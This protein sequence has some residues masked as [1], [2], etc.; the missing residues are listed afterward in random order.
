MQGSYDFH[1]DLI[2]V[3][4]H[5]LPLQDLLLVLG[6]QEHWKDSCVCVQIKFN[7]LK[8][9]PWDGIS[10]QFYDIKKKCPTFLRTQRSTNHVLQQ[11][12]GRELYETIE[13]RV[14]KKPFEQLRKRQLFRRLLKLP[15][16]DLALNL[17]L[18]VGCLPLQPP[19]IAFHDIGELCFVE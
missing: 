12:T 1:E 14:A 13:L 19:F 4:S 7:P 10:T 5:S 9:I 2:G 11:R 18:G 17:S 6:E 16:N 3:Y 8:Q 15:L